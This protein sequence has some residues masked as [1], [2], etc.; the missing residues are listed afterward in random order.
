MTESIIAEAAFRALRN[1]GLKVH[2][3]DLVKLFDTS[4]IIVRTDGRASVPQS[5]VKLARAKHPTLFH[6][7][8]LTMSAA[9]LNGAIKGMA[10]EHAREQVAAESRAF[11]ETLRRKYA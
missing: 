5:F 3:P 8:A 4:Q 11:L 9:E 7:D 1:A 10:I 6:P 2:D